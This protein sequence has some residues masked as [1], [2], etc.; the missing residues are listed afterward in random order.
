[1]QRGGGGSQKRLEVRLGT[2]HAGATDEDLFEFWVRAI[3]GMRKYGL[4]EDERRDIARMLTR[5]GVPLPSCLEWKG[6]Q[7]G[8]MAEAAAELAELTAG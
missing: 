7:Q 1:V 6:A 8:A 2:L 4:S 5:E 3:Y